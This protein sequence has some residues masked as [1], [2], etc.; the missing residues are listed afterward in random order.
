MKTARELIDETGWVPIRPRS[1]QLRHRAL[2]HAVDAHGMSEC[3][4]YYTRTDPR[5]V[6]EDEV[7]PDDIRKCGRC[8]AVINRRKGPA[9]D[10]RVVVVT[11]TYDQPVGDEILD[12]H[13]DTNL[14][15]QGVVSVDARFGQG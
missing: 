12:I 15:F 3:G 9:V 8:Q 7:L 2:L 1:G 11:I 5:V 4:L 10:K 6:P 14:N 13:R